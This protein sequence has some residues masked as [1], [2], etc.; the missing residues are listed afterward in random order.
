MK[1]RNCG[2]E[3]GESVKCCPICKA[4][5]EDRMQQQDIIEVYN[6]TEAINVMEEG[7]ELS[8]YPYSPRSRVTAGLL[9]IFFGGFGI[10]RFYLG[11]NGIALAQLFTFPLFFAGAIWGVIDGILIL[12]GQVPYDVNGVPIK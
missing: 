1:C 5:Q 2:Q 7:A 8:E 6:T 3:L 4:E 10:G 11:Y 9:Q 12:C